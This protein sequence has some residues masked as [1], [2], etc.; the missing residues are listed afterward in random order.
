MG[1]VDLFV[2]LPLRLLWPIKAI[3]TPLAARARRKYKYPIVF[4]LLLIRARTSYGEE[5]EPDIQLKSRHPA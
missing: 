1:W 5:S 4:A 3:I 2:L